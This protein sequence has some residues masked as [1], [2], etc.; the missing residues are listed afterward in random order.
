MGKQVYKVETK[1][2]KYKWIYFRNKNAND[3]TNDKL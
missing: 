1:N 3:E 2:N